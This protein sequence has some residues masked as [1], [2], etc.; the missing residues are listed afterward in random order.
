MTSEPA[1]PPSAAPIET[2]AARLEEARLALARDGFARLGPVLE[3]EDVLVL[4]EDLDRIAAEAA[5]AENP[6]GVLVHN[7]WR[8]A[9]ACARAIRSGRIAG[10]ARSLLRAREVFFF[11]D[12]LISKTPGTPTDLKWHQDYS[13]WPLDPARGVIVWIALDDAD[14]TN[15]CLRYVPGSHRRGE[16]RPTPF[17]GAGAETERADL[18]P[19]DDATADREAVAVP[20]AVGEAIAHDP[21]VWHM[22]PINRTS[23]SRRAWST[24]WIEPPA[25]WRPEHAAHPYNWELKPA[26]GAPVEGE[27]FPRF[28]G[29][30]GGNDG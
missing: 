9:T 13:Y 8:R 17:G 12:L 4:R 11:Q 27:I 1:P 16:L 23:R 3:R 14:L 20:V 26:P 18:V 22:S 21:L 2:D 29:A 7:V 6:Y 15:G 10:I 19:L 5:L 28:T 24:T 25:R 30:L